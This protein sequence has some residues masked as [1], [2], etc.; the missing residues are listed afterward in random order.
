MAEERDVEALVQS[1]Q[2]F[3]SV[4]DFECVVHPAVVG[5]Q[6]VRG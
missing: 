2:S 1:T 3:T 6:V 4:D 5:D